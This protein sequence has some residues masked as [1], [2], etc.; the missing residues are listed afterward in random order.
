[1][2]GRFLVGTA[3]PRGTC[4]RVGDL[5]GAGPA[6]CWVPVSPSR[7]GLQISPSLLYTPASHYL[8]RHITNKVL[9]PPLPQESQSSI[10]WSEH[11]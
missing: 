1:M 10:L 6:M 2:R 5:P 3:S 11:P 8:P 4:W 9:P 7:V